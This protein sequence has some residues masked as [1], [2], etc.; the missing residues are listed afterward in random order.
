MRD[1]LGGQIPTDW[2]AKLGKHLG[3]VEFIKALNERVQRAQLQKLEEH[4]FS[5]LRDPDQ[6]LSLSHIQ[7]AA[8]P[9]INNEVFMKMMMR[10]VKMR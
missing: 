6:F 5:V 9:Q 2:K 10:L 4:G 1:S 7:F 8:D 3:Q